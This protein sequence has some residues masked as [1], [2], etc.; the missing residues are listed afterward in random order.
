MLFRSLDKQSA[1][2]GDPRFLRT[3]LQVT[4]DVYEVLGP[5]VRSLDNAAAAV[6]ATADDF[7]IHD[8]RAAADFRS[9]EGALKND[10]L[11]HH[12]QPGELTDPETPGATTPSHFG[13]HDVHTPSTPAPTTPKADHDQR[14]PLADGADVPV[15]R[16]ED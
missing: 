13:V 9:L 5:A 10:P 15:I 4:G 8:A 3:L 12:T 7:R 6:I 2:A 14:E 1:S 11:P 16:P